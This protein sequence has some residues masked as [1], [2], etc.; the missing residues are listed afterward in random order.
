MD[1]HGDKC[2]L[3]TQA[4]LTLLMG[5]RKVGTE[6]EDALQSFIN[7]CAKSDA[8]SKFYRKLSETFF[9]GTNVEKMLHL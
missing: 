1:W 4:Y 2:T 6:V 5:K 9:L 7:V 8:L 3:R